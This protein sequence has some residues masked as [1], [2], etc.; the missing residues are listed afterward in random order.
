MKKIIYLLLILS[1]NSITAYSQTKRYTISGYIKEKGSLESLPGVTVYLPE[2]NKGVITNGY[3]FYSMTLETG[4]YELEIRYI[5][6]QGIKTKIVLDKNIEL[7]HLLIPS[8]VFLDEVEVNAALLE[9]ESESSQ[10]SLIKLSPKSIQDIPTLFGEK[11]VLKVLQLLPGVHSGN[12]GGTGLYVRGGG[13]DQNLII[14]DDAVVYNV[15]H[16][17][18]FFSIFN[19]DALKST[20]LY[21]GGFPARF[22]G[23]ISSVIKMDIKDGNKEAIHGKAKVGIISSSG[24]LEGPIKKGKTSFLISGRRTYA[25]LLSRAFM[26]NEEGTG[27]YYFYDL[28][29]K[30]HHEFSDKDK[31]YVSGYFGRDIFEAS[32]KD[33]SNNK[34]M[35]KL[36]WGNATATL[37]WNHQFSQKIFTN[38]SLV[39]SSYG[40]FTNIEATESNND[41][42]TIGNESTVND[43]A[44]KYDVDYFPNIN[45]AIKLGASMTF[46]RFIPSGYSLKSND[47]DDISSQVEIN[48]TES[49]IYVEDDFK[50]NGRLNAN[51]GL[52]FTHFIEKDVSY[53]NL[54]PRIS[55]GYQLTHDLA[56][57][58]SYAEMNQYIHLLS[59]SG[60][61]LPTDL[62]VSSTDR[63][64]PQ[65]SKQIALGVTKDFKNQ[66]TITLESYYK[67]SKGIITYQEGAQF[68]S[69]FSD[70]SQNSVS[71][72][73]NITTGKGIS[74]GTEFLIKKKV[75]GK[76]NGWLGY[77]LSK[78]EL[79]FDELNNGKKFLA[80]YDRR[81]DV[82]IVAIYNISDN[83]TLSATWVYGTGNKLTLPVKEQ[84]VIKTDFNTN[85]SPFY[86][87]NVQ[88]YIDRSNFTA[89]AYHRMDLSF[90]MKK[91]KK[92]GVRTWDISIYNLYGRK[93]PFYYTIIADE[94]FL[95]NNSDKKV[96]QKESFLPFLIPSISYIYEF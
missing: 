39:Y 53:Y 3:G 83:K 69:A 11:D 73:D 18:G 57:K 92:R 40:F 58:A 49:A 36:G 31:L 61:G 78:T 13:P 50:F 43:Y 15:N 66:I 12:E 7:N 80:K 34:S 56:I 10:M 93:N 29:T 47:V 71:W 68:S 85:T 19:G 64:K 2:I 48:S 86:H 1:M 23:R 76:F 88:T 87:E 30:I 74:Y 4:E 89:E 62:W 21:K 65:H 79:Q 77:T 52:R 91:P 41:K 94:N 75:S 24:I 60:E 33:D 32:T 55:L 26:N 45:H 14:L 37:R 8:T 59:N 6:F 25:D 44:W 22:G 46:H 84:P 82:S 90:Q 20:E 54:E 63:I 9:K 42:T 67:A 96:L 72:E 51:L 70:I 35:F 81:H 28:N 95:G 27:G 17:F 16:L 5:G 38:T